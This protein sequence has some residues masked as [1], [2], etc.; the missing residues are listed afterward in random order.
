MLVGTDRGD[1]PDDHRDERYHDPYDAAVGASSSFQLHQHLVM[2]LSCQ[3]T[4]PPSLFQ[5][6]LGTRSRSAHAPSRTCTFRG[7]GIAAGALNAPAMS[8]CC[9]PFDLPWERDAVQGVDQVVRRSWD[10]LTRRRS[11]T[12]RLLGLPVELPVF[13]CCCGAPSQL[14][15]AHRPNP[16]GRPSELAPPQR[17][18]EPEGGS[19]SSWRGWVALATRP[20]TS[21]ARGVHPKLAM[22]DSA[23][24]RRA[25]RL[26]AISLSPAAPRET[27][28][29][30]Y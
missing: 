26:R 25:F 29:A 20:N 4:V 21:R 27:P 13:A 10:T 7:L 30:P 16:D 6:P 18:V 28:A 12:R 9:A 22:R 15:S 2:T 19:G 8:P 5:C 1:G 14:G 17:H 24:R 11:L 23:A 3:R